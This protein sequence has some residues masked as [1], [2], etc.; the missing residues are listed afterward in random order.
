M[1]LYKVCYS[2]GWK[3]REILC[4][5]KLTAIRIRLLVGRL[6]MYSDNYHSPRIYAL[7][8]K[9]WAEDND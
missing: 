9:G 6:S 4:A 5:D 7:Q 3:R 2:I 8:E 1:D